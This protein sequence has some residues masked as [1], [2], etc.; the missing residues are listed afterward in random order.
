M[1]PL[2]FQSDLRL[3]Q[4]GG[5]RFIRAIETD[6]E[7][8]SDVDR[9]LIASSSKKRCCTVAELGR[10][11]ALRRCSWTVH[12]RRGIRHTRTWT[13]AS[14]RQATWRQS[15]VT[16]A[17]P[18]WLRQVVTYT[19]AWSVDDTEAAGIRIRPIHALSE[20]CHVSVRQKMSTRRSRMHSMTSSVLLCNDSTFRQ[21]NVTCST[22]K[23]ETEMTRA[24]CFPRTRRPTRHPRLPEARRRALRPET[25]GLQPGPLLRRIGGGEPGWGRSARTSGDR[26]Q[27][28][29]KL[30]CRLGKTGIECHQKLQISSASLK[31]SDTSRCYALRHS[32]CY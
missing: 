14:Q 10:Y 30:T 13:P 32:R 5:M 25:Q 19:R 1:L 24:L 9:Y 23:F 4:L 18:P 12:K 2:E 29:H 31:T 3:R 28:C 8:A 22:G 20:S 15:L 17:T 26:G 11:T 21:A 7:V 16:T 6:V 27:T